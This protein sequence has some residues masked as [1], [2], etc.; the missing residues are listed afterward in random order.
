MASSAAHSTDEHKHPHPSYNRTATLK[1]RKYQRTKCL[2]RRNNLIKKALEFYEDFGYDV[3]V[4]LRQGNRSYIVTNDAPS[5]PPV[6]SNI[7]SNFA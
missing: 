2:K 7:V 3:Y 6:H 1:L 5:W 4:H